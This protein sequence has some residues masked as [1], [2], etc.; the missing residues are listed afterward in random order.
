[1]EKR[2][3]TCARRELRTGAGET[4]DDCGQALE[5]KDPNDS[6][7]PRMGRNAPAMAG[8]IQALMPDSD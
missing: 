2:S 4:D 1:M 6:A 5:R 7:T 3:A 8:P